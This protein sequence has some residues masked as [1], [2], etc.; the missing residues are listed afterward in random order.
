MI[1]R[2]LGGRYAIIENVDAGGMAYIYKA[3]CKKTGNIVAVKVLKEEFEN[4]SEYVSRFKKEAEAAFSLEHKNIVHVTDIGC[5]EGS[6]YMVMEYIEGRPLKAIIEEKVYLGEEEAIRYAIQVCDALE[7]AHS[8]GIIHRDIKPQNILVDS[9]GQAKIT[10]F[11]IATSISSE[12]PKENQV[13]GSVYYISP[14]QAKG[15]KTDY[16]TD[17]YSLGI[18]LYEMLTGKMPHTGDKTVTVALKH[19]N[20][21]LVP[22]IEV[23][24]NISRAVSN[25]VLKAASKAPKDRYR[26]AQAFK[27]DLTRALDEPD[28]EFVDIPKTLFDEEKARIHGKNKIWKVCILAALLVIAGVAVFLGFYLFGQTPQDMVEVTNM[29]GMAAAGAQ[30]LLQSNGL[31]A[32]IVFVSSETIDEGIVISQSVGEGLQVSKGTEV[33]LTVSS[34]PAG[35]VMPD[36]VGL[37]YIEAQAKIES[38]G[39]NPA[40]AD[41]EVRGDVLQGRVIFQMPEADTEITEDELITLTISGE[42]P[43][44]GSLMPSLKGMPVDQAVKFLQGSGY[45]LFSVY[46]D[47]SEAEEGQVINQSPVE[48]AQA[49]YTNEVILHISEYANKK[50]TGIFNEKFDVAEKGSKVRI[51]LIDVINGVDIPIVVNEGTLN[52]EAVSLNIPISALSSGSKTVAV[53]I[54]NVEAYTYEVSF[55]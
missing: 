47:E 20:E 34:G 43:Q 36:L 53:Y 28:G 17:I 50:Y 18:V 4:S 26:S 2:V 3:V 12:E 23:N 13:M 16:R 31:I 24:S 42:A 6:Y 51:V 33:V 21:K 48:G 52:A 25:I 46:E 49:F 30:S 29:E 19:I 54:N 7:A 55:Y 14:E 15:G 9:E 22:P 8:E 40:D 1:G 39:L 41:Y 32:N 38:M 10:D 37:S 35:L 44:E 45:T 11:G 27:A 5:D